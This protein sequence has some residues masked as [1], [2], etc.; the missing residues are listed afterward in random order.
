MWNHRDARRNTSRYRVNKSADAVL[1]DGSP[2]PFN[3]LP[4]LVVR[5]TQVQSLQMAS[6]V[7]NVPPRVRLVRDQE[8]TLATEA[9]VHLVE[10]VGRCEQCVGGHYPAEK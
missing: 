1:R 8:S 2:F 10:H 3:H 6:N 7:S 4:K 9:C 5:T